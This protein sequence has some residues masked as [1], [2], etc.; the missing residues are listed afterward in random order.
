MKYIWM[1]SVS[2][3]CR[4]RR[5]PNWTGLGSWRL[6]RSHDHSGCDLHRRRYSWKQHY[7]WRSWHGYVTCVQAQGKPCHHFSTSLHDVLAT[8]FRLSPW[9][10]CHTLWPGHIKD[11]IWWWIRHPKNSRCIPIWIHPG[12]VMNSISSS[13]WPPVTSLFSFDLD[14]QSPLSVCSASLTWLY[15]LPVEI[16]FQHPLL[17]HGGLSQ[18]SV[19]QLSWLY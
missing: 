17:V 4:R 1:Y 15:Y 16:L 11:H 2:S 8:Y 19:V 14:L 3:F 10:W 12:N 13:F 9:C 7:T 6:C 5:L 18:P